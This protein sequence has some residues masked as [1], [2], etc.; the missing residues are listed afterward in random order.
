MRLPSKLSAKNSYI[1]RL[2]KISSVLSMFLTI[3]AIY[4]AIA[5]DKTNASNELAGVVPPQIDNSQDLDSYTDTEEQNQTQ[6]LGTQAPPKIPEPPAMPPPIQTP[7]PEPEPEPTKEEPPDAK[8]QEA[9]KAEPDKSDGE[10]TNVYVTYYGWPDNDP[11]GGAI[12]YPSDEYSETLHNS[13]GGD[14]TYDN[15]ISFASDPDLFSPGTIIYVPYI[16]K[17]IIMEDMCVTCIE[18]WQDNEKKHIDI[19]ME[20]NENYEDELYACQNQ[21]T[22]SKTEIELNPPKDRKVSDDP[23][24]NKE[25]GNC[26]SDG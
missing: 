23:L 9:E 10:I 4:V 19:W 3:S 12:A 26:L 18:N 11:P 1:K 17:Y 25:K 6:T 22:R 16:K 13:T 15:P 24:F 7:E 8:N 14:G 5:I 20:S 2:A 21:W